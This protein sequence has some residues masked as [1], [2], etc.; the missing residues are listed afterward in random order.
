MPIMKS[1]SIILI[2]LAF[3]AV[4]FS[5]YR[6]RAASSP[7][8][9]IAFG[10]TSPGA[11][12]TR[13]DAGRERVRRTVV[14]AGL[15]EKGSTL[16]EKDD[17]RVL[18]SGDPRLLALSEEEAVW[19]DKHYYPTPEE[20]DSLSGIDVDALSGTKDPKLAVLQGL[21]LVE[22]GQLSAAA[23]VLDK[24]TALGSIY[25][26]EEAAVAEYNLMNE[27]LG[28]S[29]LDG[30]NI[31]MAR[32]EVARIL[33][34]H[35]VQYLVDTHLPGYDVRSNAYAVQ[36]HVTEFMRQLGENARHLGVQSPGTDP[37]PN[38]ELWNDLYE[39]YRLQGGDGG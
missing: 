29:S 26:Y 7:P 8:D 19:L 23:S 6:F 15:G 28:G 33:G 9:A 4:L 17:V 3:I 10:T 12:A 37:R 34:D 35:T 24:A 20:L 32:L 39:L 25:A 16:M 31:L 2:F 11:T 36:Q 13:G 30:Q 18:F 14:A 1:S 5:V 38:A 21:A 22:H 27:R